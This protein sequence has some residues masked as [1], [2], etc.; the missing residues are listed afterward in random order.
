[1]DSAIKN[2]KELK[3]DTQIE[4]KIEDLTKDFPYQENYFDYIYARLV[5]HYF[6]YQELD[7][8]F[9][10]MRKSLKPSGHIF[11]VVRSEKNIDT[12]KPDQEYDPITRLTTV[13]Y[14]DDNKNVIG[15]GVRYFHSPETIREH[16]ERAGF[17][18]D[19]I[20]ECQEQLYKDFMRTKIAP[21]LD[22]VIEVHA[23]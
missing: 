12:N 21:R 19:Y 16:L 20:K 10:K 6:S 11:I 13:L 9:I 23:K 1:M 14:R 17:E 2:I 7:A 5:L 4:A 15:K 22:H 3:L 18:I 8:I